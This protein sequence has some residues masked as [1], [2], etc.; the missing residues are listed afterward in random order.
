MSRLIL[1]LSVVILCLSAC[2]PPP[3][4][5]NGA[6]RKS[7]SA[8][9]VVSTAKA[10]AKDV[11]SSFQAS[12]SF[13]AE[14]T[15]DIAPAVSGRVAATPVDAGDF[16]K[17]GQV[18]CRLEARDAQLKLDQARAGLEQSKFFLHQAQSRVGWTADAKFDPENV[19]EVSSARAAYESAL[20]SAKLAAAD[21]RRY[22][23]LVQSGDV[24]QSSYEKA[25][26]QQETA[27]AAASS[28][29][30]QYEAQVNNARQNFGAIEAAQAALDAAESQFAQ[31]QKGLEDTSVRAPFDGF[32]TD[33][34]AAVGQWLGTGSKVATLV[35]IST[36]KLQLQIPEQQA[37]MVHKGVV[38]TAR[39][40]AYP[41]RDFFGKIVAVVPSV[42]SNSRAFKAEAR[43]DNPGAEL[44]PGMFANAK[45]MLPGSEPA[46]FVP[47]GAVFYDNTTDANYVYS[48]VDEKAGPVAHLNVV[49]K[50]DTD[51]TQVRILSG[52]KGDE[53]VVV[54]NQAE[55]YD[56]VAVDIH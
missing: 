18:I 43:F 10:V 1:P 2:A 21:A 17:K 23:N 44:R 24:S 39:V 38:V 29:R 30:K 52:L 37:A 55:L 31:A 22:E 35:H 46:V 53:T 54:D 42:D 12:G 11:Q 50:G 51:G 28:A 32:I 49:L 16:V 6:S 48:V 9:I 25:K 36:V 45:V 47:A 33:R 27:E 19:P 3:D 26:T 14:E 4:R 5:G 13:I 15:S 56:G 41:D 7:T 20:A 8:K 40:A 34:P